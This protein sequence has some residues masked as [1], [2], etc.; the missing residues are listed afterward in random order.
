MADLAIDQSDEQIEQLLNCT[1]EFSEI[2]VGD[3][4]MTDRWLWEKVGADSA[5]ALSELMG[6]SGIL[7]GSVVHFRSWTEVRLIKES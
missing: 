1:V 4:F 3:R 2:D 7:L 5:K 6:K